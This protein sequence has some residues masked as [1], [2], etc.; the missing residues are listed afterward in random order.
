MIDWCDSFGL[1]EIAAGPTHVA[2][3]HVT[4]RVATFLSLDFAKLLFNEE[5]AHFISFFFLKI[6]AYCI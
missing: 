2:K 1:R 4:S 5:V 3:C 6:F